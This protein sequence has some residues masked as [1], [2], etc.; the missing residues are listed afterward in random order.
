MLAHL[1]TCTPSPLGWTISATIGTVVGSVDASP[2]AAVSAEHR[3][4]EWMSVVSPSSDAMLS[5]KNAALEAKL[6]DHGYSRAA[7]TIMPMSVPMRAAPLS[8]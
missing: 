7:S 6:R 2:P 1:L 8:G 4:R 3:P 5:R